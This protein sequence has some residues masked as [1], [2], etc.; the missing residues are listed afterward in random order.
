MEKEYEIKGI[1]KIIEK[2]GKEKLTK[3]YEVEQDADFK[4]LITET[5]KKIGV[6]NGLEIATYEV[7][8]MEEIYKGGYFSYT[9]RVYEKC[10]Q[11]NGKALIG[12]NFP[13]YRNISEVSDLFFFIDEPIK[14][15]KIKKM[16]PKIYIGGAHISNYIMRK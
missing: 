11:N 2:V 7:G 6:P 15:E 1:D 5:L 10:C 9:D 8:N 16:F 14:E 3:Y 4:E 12:I 13:I